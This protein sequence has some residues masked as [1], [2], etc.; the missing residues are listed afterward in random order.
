MR[1]LA[2]WV[3]GI[4]LVA[5]IAGCAA[6]YSLQN[7][8]VYPNAAEG[9]MDRPPP[10]GVIQHWLET[11]D[12]A[13]VESWLFLP[14]GASAEARAPAVIFFHGNADYIET[15]IEYA[16]YYT[17][18]GF[19][20]LMVEYRG[21]RRSTGT[22]SEAALA[23]DADAFFDWL[24]QRP[25]VDAA[26]IGVHGQS[27]GAAIA[28]TLASRRPVRTLVMVSPFRSLPALLGRYHL[29]G[30]LA[31]ER[32]DNETAIT[33]FDGPL[34]IVHGEAD[35][36]VPVR[37]GRRLAEVAGDRATFISYPGVDHD[38]P[39]DWR[40]FGRDLADFYVA[41]GM[42]TAGHP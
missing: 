33:R 28:A 41:H 29:P 14:P 10:S 23:A 36:I 3:S 22:P 39:W 38:V 27:L 25:E 31:R 18:Q 2:A 4:V 40:V 11:P 20:C 26:R 19:A 15:K 30:A 7:E 32:F 24:A 16:D 34:L 6:T 12:G 35:E 9:P 8:F 21:Y 13:R 1:K 37:Q 42:V 5:A 17:S